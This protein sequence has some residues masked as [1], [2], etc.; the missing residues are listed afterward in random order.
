[1]AVGQRA[2][3]PAL[4]LLLLL[5]LGGP[6]AARAQSEALCSLLTAAG[7]V[8]EATAEGVG[9]EAAVV[10]DVVAEAEARLGPLL[11]TATG[12]LANLTGWDLGPDNLQALAVNAFVSAVESDRAFVRCGGNLDAVATVVRRALEQGA[13]DAARRWER[14]SSGEA[15]ATNRTA[16]EASQQRLR[17]FNAFVSPLLRS[18]ANIDFVSQMV[19]PSAGGQRHTVPRATANIG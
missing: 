19:R 18:N 5:L 2:A 11:T 17:A 6:G 4:L 12:R 1:M 13:F 15:A 8:A 9:A 16:A 3:A 7:A 14:Y 10:G